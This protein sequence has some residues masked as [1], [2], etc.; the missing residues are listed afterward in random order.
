MS[1]KVELKLGR[2]VKKNEKKLEIKATFWGLESIL[3]P[4]CT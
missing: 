4:L 3:D 1:I 2:F